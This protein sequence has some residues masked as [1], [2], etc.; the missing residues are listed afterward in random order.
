[1]PHVVR[2]ELRAFRAG[3]EHVEGRRRS[4]IARINNDEFLSERRG[5]GRVKDGE[6]LNLVDERA[7]RINDDDRGPIRLPKVVEDG[8]S[9]E[10]TL[11][12]AGATDDVS[13]LEADSLRDSE[14]E[15]K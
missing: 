13:V 10:G 8:L 9:D 11:A 4:A 1:M 2:V 15:G 14:R 5:V 7:V 12:P 6:T 3:V